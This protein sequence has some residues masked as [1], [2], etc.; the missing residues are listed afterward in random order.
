MMNFIKGYKTYLT[1]AGAV[2]YA[3]LVSLGIVPGIDFVWQLFGAATIA[4]LR[5]AMPK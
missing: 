4:S 5:D 2:I 3:G 1:T